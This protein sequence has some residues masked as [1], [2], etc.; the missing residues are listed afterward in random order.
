MSFAESNQIFFITAAHR[1]SHPPPGHTKRS[2][3]GFSFSYQTYKEIDT[4]MCVATGNTA[5][6]TDQWG[7][8]RELIEIHLVIFFTD[9]NAH[10]DTSS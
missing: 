3:P 9:S 2:Q 7:G 10:N 4:N 8:R 5:Q 6:H 1:H